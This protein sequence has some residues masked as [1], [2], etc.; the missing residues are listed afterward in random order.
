M[1]DNR[2]I[3]KKEFLTAYGNNCPTIQF[4]G[5]S[6]ADGNYKIISSNNGGVKTVL[7]ATY[8]TDDLLV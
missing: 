6:N 3:I 8:P 4:K 7:S 1:S 5:D 2:V